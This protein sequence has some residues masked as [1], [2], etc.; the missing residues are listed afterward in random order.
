[1]GIRWQFLFAKFKNRLNLSDLHDATDHVFESSVKGLPDMFRALK[2][3]EPG[4]DH[5]RLWRD[6][7][8]KQLEIIA[9]EHTRQSQAAECRR[10][11]LKAKEDH[12]LAARLVETS[13]AFVCRMFFEEDATS[14]LADE[15]VIALAAKHFIFRSVDIT[16]FA[17]LYMEQLNST[18]DSD[19]FDDTYSAMCKIEADFS[20]RETIHM[21]LSS[22]DTEKENGWDKFF[23]EVAQ[24]AAAEFRQIKDHFKEN[25]CLLLPEKPDPTVFNDFRNRTL[26]AIEPYLKS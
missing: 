17:M 21:Y 19:D 4:I 12:A 3:S 18:L 5:G 10:M 1:M 11:L 7:F 14:K 24:P 20:V 6:G 8:A 15:T 16:A 2:E 26:K 22:V 23:L 13:Q 25:L 9:A